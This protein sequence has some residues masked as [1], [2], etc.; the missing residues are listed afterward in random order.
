MVLV[1]MQDLGNIHLKEKKWYLCNVFLVFFFGNSDI[2]IDHVITNV[3]VAF[4][5]NEVHFLS[6]FGKR[7]LNGKKV[8]DLLLFFPPVP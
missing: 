2:I 3:G 5:V 6:K 1:T 4:Q 7:M 8:M